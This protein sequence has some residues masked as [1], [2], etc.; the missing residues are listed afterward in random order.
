MEKLAL[1]SLKTHC[2]FVLSL[3]DKDFLIALQDRPFRNCGN[4]STPMVVICLKSF[5]RVTSNIDGIV[6]F[7]PCEKKVKNTSDEDVDEDDD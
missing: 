2:N 5:L 1:S 7:K 6:D 4:F 3:M